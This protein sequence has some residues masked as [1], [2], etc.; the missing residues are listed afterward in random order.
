MPR[1]RLRDDDIIFEGDMIDGQPGRFMSPRGY[2]SLLILLLFVGSSL[3]VWYA[4]NKRPSYGPDGQPPLIRADARP[5]KV[6]PD[7]PGGDDFVS[8]AP[9]ITT[10]LNP[11]A[12]APA[13]REEVLLSPPPSAPVPLLAPRDQAPAATADAGA[14][15][16]QDA[17][18]EPSAASPWQAAMDVAARPPSGLHEDVELGARVPD[19]GADQAAGLFEQQPLT[20]L[21]DW[22]EAMDSDLGLL[23]DE[24]LTSAVAED[25]AEPAPAT[26]G[27]E[28]RF[29]VQFASLTSEEQ[30]E[31][32]L[33]TLQ[34]R[35]A[36]LRDVPLQVVEGESGG[37]RVFRVQAL[38]FTDRAAA[39]SLCDDVLDAGGAC[40]VI[41]G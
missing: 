8:D 39:Q 21:S 28:G 19:D 20:A 23:D 30:A 36:P 3:Y 33:T 41:E 35:Y 24:V 4:Y 25:S 6:A 14:A 5:I 10:L 38:D 27:A 37:A 7:N 26:G 13:P 15:D 34:R 9:L 17:Q 29:R 11:N 2:L 18:G 16:V 40:W 1:D 32:G 22:I 12:D 31:T